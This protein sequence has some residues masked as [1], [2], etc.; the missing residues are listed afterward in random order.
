MIKKVIL[1][2][3]VRRPLSLKNGQMSPRN[4]SLQFVVSELAS[5]SMFK[6]R[7]IMFPTNLHQ[8]ISVERRDE[9]GHGTIK[10]TQ[11]LC[12][13]GSMWVVPEMRE[14]VVAAQTFLTRYEKD[15]IK[16][17][18]RVVTGDK[19][20]IHYWS[21]KMKASSSVWKTKDE[22]LPRKFKNEHSAWKV[23]LM[24]FWGCRAWFTPSLVLKPPI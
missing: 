15:R 9:V 5:P 24:A 22:L 7:I 11:S 6:C 12:L 23:M 21:T 16:L 4:S 2:F 8:I 19:C 14:R 13:L 10:P 18:E 1:I 3:C 17:L 20:W